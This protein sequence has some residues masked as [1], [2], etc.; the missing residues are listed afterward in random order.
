MERLRVDELVM[1]LLK[2]KDGELKEKEK[3]VRIMAKKKKKK[4][5]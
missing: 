1:L 4:K 3:G 2:R 5:K